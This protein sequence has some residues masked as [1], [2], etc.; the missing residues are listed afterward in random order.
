MVQGH[1]KG[2]SIEES[3]VAAKKKLYVDPE[4]NLNTLNDDE[5]RTEFE[6][7]IPFIF[8]NFVHQIERAKLIMD[9]SFESRKIGP[10]DPR[11]QYDIEVRTHTCG[12]SEMLDLHVLI[13]KVDFGNTEDNKCDWD[14]DDET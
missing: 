4:K 3:L 7:E 11:F 5:V 13:T 10:D 9:E 8:P 2:Q 14:S 6:N 12:S 1:M